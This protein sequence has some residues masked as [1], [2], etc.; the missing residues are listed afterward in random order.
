M[1]EYY[2]KCVNNDSNGNIEEVGYGSNIDKY[3]SDTKSKSSVI[4]D[5]DTLNKTVKTAY[6]SS[7]Q[8]EWVEGDNIHTV[9]GEYIRTDGNE[10][11]SDNLENLGSC[12]DDI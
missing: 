1:V 4:Y 11:E 6:Y 12:P 2:V 7:Q 9:E 5:I 8:G 3:V 10:V